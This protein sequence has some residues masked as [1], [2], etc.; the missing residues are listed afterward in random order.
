LAI[1]NPERLSLMR[2]YR[3]EQLKASGKFPSYNS[4]A[5]KFFNLLNEN[6][7][8]NGNHALSNG[9]YEIEGYSVDYYSPSKNLIIEWD[10]EPH[11]KGRN[12]TLL[13]K[14]IIRQNNIISKSPNIHFLRIREKTKVI[15]PISSNIP[16][17]II[18]PIISTLNKF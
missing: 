4:N 10:E 13:K 3:L 12:N 8:W 18:D 11:Y 17:E 14:D 15:S 1:N 7:N 9:E 16:S 6:V 2:K 5:C